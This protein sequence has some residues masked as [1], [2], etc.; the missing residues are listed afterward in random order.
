M[1]PNR[2]S[3]QVL[4]C[5]VIAWTDNPAPKRVM[6]TSLRFFRLIACG[7][8]LSVPAIGQDE[9]NAYELDPLVVVADR[10]FAAAGQVSFLDS[11]WTQGSVVEF[12]PRS[13]DEVLRRTPIMGFLDRRDAHAANPTGQ[14]PSLRN[15]AP[16]APA[17]TLVLRDGVPQNDP[18]GGWVRWTR[19]DPNSLEGIQVLSSAQAASWGHQSVGGVILMTTVDSWGELHRFGLSA[20]DRY[21]FRGAAHHT[22]SEDRV[23]AYVGGSAYRT[24]GHYF[25]HSDDRGP[26]D[27]PVRIDTRSVDAKL[28]WQ[29][30]AK[31]KVEGATGFYSEDR[32]TGS[33]LEYN[34]SDVWDASL[35]ASGGRG[36]TSWGVLAYYQETEM[37]ASYSSIDDARESERLVREQFIPAEGMGGSVTLAHQFAPAFS[38][39]AGADYRQL[40]GETREDGGAGLNRRLNAGGEQ[41]FVGAFAKA[42]TEFAPNSLLQAEARVD[43]WTNR[44]GR[45]LEYLNSTGE[46]L[47]EEAYPQREDLS[48]SFS[49]SY[50][51]RS[52]PELR[53]NL[54]GA[55]SF[56]LANLNELYRPFRGGSGAYEP[57]PA[58]DPERYLSVEA[59]VAWIPRRNWQLTSGF[60]HYWITD[61]IANIFIL[62]GPGTGLDGVVVPAGTAL[63]Q[64]QNVEAA[65]AFG[66]LTRVRWSPQEPFELELTHLY[67]DSRYTSSPTQPDLEGKRFPNIPY[68]RVSAQATWTVRDWLSLSAGMD[69]EDKVLEDQDL[70]TEID[71]YTTVR[72]GA[73]LRFSER[74]SMSLRVE[75]LLDAEILTGVDRD[76]V[77]FIKQ[78]RFVWASFQVDL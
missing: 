23:A 37:A 4:R 9:E 11:S 32:I 21:S 3:R 7:A 69:Y 73:L 14:G 46:V 25:V 6:E 45:R 51:Y 56:R 27:R 10:S 66:W 49:F 40:K 63:F 78:P 50:V 36:N 62:D 20:G 44:D 47:L 26:V 72:V 65:R 22:W 61:T 1:A 71:A 31:I 70:E 19:Y 29:A 42:V 39:M 54:G 55:Y 30:D 43:W 28:A 77:R 75:N 16:N 17:R 68:H 76:G 15:I 24:E 35:R 33:P 67:S 59:S 52:S 8:L 57:N 41:V 13:V 60:Y 74:V 48:P 12:S 53:W 2:R 34:R 5:E 18:F 38:V 64:R 58:L